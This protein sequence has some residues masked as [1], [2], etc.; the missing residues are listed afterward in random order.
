LIPAFLISLREGLEAALVVGIV[1]AYAVRIGRSDVLPKIWIGVIA[2]LAVSLGSG[3]LIL[4]TIQRLPLVVQETI[5]GGAALVAIAVLTWML[6]W[7]RRHGR[8]MKGE[9]EQGVDLALA[10]GSVVALAGLAFVSVGREGLETV[11]FL[12]VVFSASG[13]GAGPA[14][15]AVGGLVLAVGVG[16]AIFAAG[17]RIDLRRFFQT[18]G[19]LLIFVAAGLCAFAVGE[20]GEAGLIGNTGTVFD[21]SG[22]LPET[23]PV[24]A[25][26]AGLF[27]YRATPTP[28]EVAAYLGYLVP[29]L[30]VFILG[31]RRPLPAAR[32]LA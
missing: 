23:G 20:F 3:V 21:L 14:I 15:G 5:E 1:A 28:L 11:L 7:M 29:V 26:L 13:Q 2:A 4:A 9:L 16:W 27:G 18:T 32:T 8:S 24:G 6:F 17:K 12:A 10:N 30:G 25:V 31:G 19:V 22:V